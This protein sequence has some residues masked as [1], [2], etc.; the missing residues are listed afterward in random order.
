MSAT[1]GTGQIAAEGPIGLTTSEQ[2]LTALAIA[3][4]IG[5]WSS[6]GARNPLVFALTFA[7]KAS[8]ARQRPISSHER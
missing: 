7:V 3:A 5:V 8:A 6:R 1:P 2:P 4:A